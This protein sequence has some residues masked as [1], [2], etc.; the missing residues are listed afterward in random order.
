MV[1]IQTKNIW[2]GLSLA[3]FAHTAYGFLK[4]MQQYD[5]ITKPFGR[6]I[7]RYYP[8]DDRSWIHFASRLFASSKIKP[9]DPYSFLKEKNNLQTAKEILASSYKIHV[10][11]KPKYLL[12]TLT[13]IFQHIIRDESFAHKMTGLKAQL[14]PLTNIEISDQQMA[15]FIVIYAD[16]TQ[17]QKG[18]QSILQ[19]LNIIL[20]GIPHVELSDIP[21]EKAALLKNPHNLC[22]RFNLPAIDGSHLI[23]Y[24][25]G[26]G[27]YKETNGFLLSKEPIKAHEIYKTL[28][29]SDHNITFV[30]V[31]IPCN[32]TLITQVAGYNYCSGIQHHTYMPLKKELTKRNISTDV[33]DKEPSL[34][35]AFFENKPELLFSFFAREIKPD[36]SNLMTGEQIKELLERALQ[37]AKESPDVASKK[38]TKEN[39]E[40]LQNSAFVTGPTSFAE[41]VFDK[42]SNFALYPADFTGTI[43]DYHLYL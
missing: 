34:L 15:A 11:P 6:S 19:T 29:L 24:A 42:E 36:T 4:E 20:E 27:I 22:P 40:I 31:D 26:E 17:G 8:K 38:Y 16:P 14:L 41:M 39:L 7:I 30:D 43:R 3:L 5:E 12:N 35:V 21:P 1:C 25:Q 10:M 28:P 9:M 18:A 2:Y 32:N 33:I 37:E 23:C 13:I